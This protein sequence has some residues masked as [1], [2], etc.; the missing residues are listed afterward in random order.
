MRRGWWLDKFCFPDILLALVVSHLV[1]RLE[2]FAGDFLESANA[3]HA[4]G[5]DVVISSRR[6]ILSS[7]V[8]HEVGEP[9]KVGDDFGDTVSIANLEPC[10]DE[11]QEGMPN[12][13][14]AVSPELEAAGY[15]QA[16]LIYSAEGAPHFNLC[17]I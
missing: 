4:A 7:L 17:L 10:S 2:L 3:L 8:K 6:D 1:H 14:G 5:P 12:F 16:G 11:L 13:V 15:S 9:F